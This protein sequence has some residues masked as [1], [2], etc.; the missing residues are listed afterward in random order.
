MINL[1]DRAE[2][3]LEW[4]DKFKQVGDIAIQYDQAH[5]ALPWAGI[6]FIL[7]VC[8]PVAVV[9]CDCSEILIRSERLGCS[10]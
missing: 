2:K 5:A 6:R 7:Q 8:L 9:S 10:E 4:V 1:R 3:I